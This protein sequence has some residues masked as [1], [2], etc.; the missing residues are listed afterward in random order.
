ML[1]R[2]WSDI[3]VPANRQPR[4][5]KASLPSGLNAGGTISETDVIA[6]CVRLQEATQHILWLALLVAQMSTLLSNQ[7]CF[8]E[9]FHSTTRTFEFYQT[10]R[11]EI[12]F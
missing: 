2:Q 8:N 10:L 12:Y 4:L 11:V 5:S 6:I 7:L 3:L 9:A 1:P